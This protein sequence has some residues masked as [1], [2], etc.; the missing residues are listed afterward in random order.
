MAAHAKCEHA[1]RLCEERGM[2]LGGVICL[3]TVTL[4]EFVPS[5]DAA[6]NCVQPKVF[7]VRPKTAP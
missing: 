4:T 7:P 5:A 3:L 1:P 6:M 2:I